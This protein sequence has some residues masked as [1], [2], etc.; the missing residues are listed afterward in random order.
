MGLN[1]DNQRDFKQNQLWDVLVGP[2]KPRQLMRSSNTLLP[3]EI[4]E[5]RPRVGYAGDVHG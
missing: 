2:G 5:E 3:G 4:Q 1:H